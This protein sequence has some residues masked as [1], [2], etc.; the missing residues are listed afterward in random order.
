MYRQPYYSVGS[1]NS[2][3]TTIYAVSSRSTT[4]VVPI[5]LPPGSITTHYVSHFRRGRFLNCQKI[6]HGVH[7]YHDLLRLHI[8]FPYVASR[9]SRFDHGCL[10]RGCR[11]R[12]EH[13]V[14]AT[15]RFYCKSSAELIEYTMHLC[16]VWVELQDQFHYFF[17]SHVD[18]LGTKVPTIK[19]QLDITL[20]LC[21]AYCQHA[22]FQ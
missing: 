13:S 20:R 19:F 1:R 21:F 14:N 7:G 3:S 22:N 11:D 12:R 8:Q 17:I 16:C 2:R 4:Q 9:L 10:K 6:C 18:T 15:L 5:V